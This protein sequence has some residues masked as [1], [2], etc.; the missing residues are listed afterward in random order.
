[1]VIRF[2]L[3]AL[4]LLSAAVVAATASA[5]DWP[6]F[7]GDAQVT[8]DVPAD[9]SGPIEAATAGRVHARWTQTLDGAVI[10]SPLYSSAAVPDARDGVVYVATQAGTVYALSA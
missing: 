5:G 4:A 9:A 7:G 3:L 6:R 2:A 1:M 10:A 8:N